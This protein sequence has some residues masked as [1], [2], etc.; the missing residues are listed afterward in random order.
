MRTTRIC[1]HEDYYDTD[2]LLGFYCDLTGEGCE[3]CSTNG[4][5]CK[6]YIMPAPEEDVGESEEI[7]QS[8]YEPSANNN[9]ICL[10]DYQKSKNVFDYIKNKDK[11]Q[12]SIEIDLLK[13]LSANR[14][15][16][17][18]SIPLHANYKIFNTKS[19]RNHVKRAF[20]ENSLYVTCSFEEVT[21][22]YNILK[23]DYPIIRIYNIDDN[24]F[25]F[26]DDI[27]VEG[28]IEELAIMERTRR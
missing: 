24:Y 27:A 8:S 16:I 3:Y 4:L 13:I 11:E 25:V 5:G 20:D 9:V 18:G 1:G 12:L 22:V 21:E 19:I 15:N 17:N 28:Y 14:D 2:S 6:N 23:D 26:K 10:A 7:M